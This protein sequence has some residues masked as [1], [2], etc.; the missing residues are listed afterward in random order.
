MAGSTADKFTATRNAA[1]PNSARVTSGRTSGVFSLSCDNLAGWPVTGTSAV[2][3]VTYQINTSDEIVAGTQQDWLGLVSGNNIGSMVLKDGTDNGNVIGDVVEML[4]TAAFGQGLDDGI[5]VGHNRDG[6]HKAS[7]PLT[8][9]QITTSINDSGGNEVIKTPATASAVNEITVTNAAT[10]VAPSISATGGDSAVH[11]NL[12]GKGLAKTVTVGAGAA[13]IFPYDY[14]VSGCVWTGD[15]LGGTR[16]GSMTAGVV[17][18][19][20]NPVTVALVT[21]HTFTASK[22]T[23]V[24]VLDGGAGAGTVVYTEVN[25]NAA[26]AALAANSIRIGIVVTAAGSIAA[27]GSINQGQEDRIVPIASSIPYAVT[28]SLGNLICPRDPNRK[29]IGY[30]QTI[31]T[32]T[33]ASTSAVQVTGVSCPVIVPTGRKVEI[34]SIIN[35]SNTTGGDGSALTLWDGVVASGTQLQINTQT[36]ASANQ[37]Q[38]LSVIAIVTPATTSKTYNL[39]LN[40]VTG[41]TAQAGAGSTQPVAIIVKLV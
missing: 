5:G 36:S 23:Y 12:R 15:S 14:V 7:L 39:G 29:I 41:G 2:H 19:N 31:S 9:P 4:P 17:V 10:G 3:F 35:A 30:R 22:D 20:G 11:L 34:T 28:D 13:V 21:A 40:A 1:R 16:A 27:A 38:T 25:N 6:T 8:T 33:T 24:D 26:S 32:F 18:I 37:G